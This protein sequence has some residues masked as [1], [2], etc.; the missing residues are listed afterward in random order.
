MRKLLIG[1]AL[2]AV[3]GA[4]LLA[5]GA[6]K[7]ISDLV[8]LPQGSWA[9]G[10]LFPMVDL[11]ASATKKTSVADFDARFF[12]LTDVLAVSNGGTNS[13]TALNNNRVMRSSGGAIVESNA[14]TASRALVSDTNGIP[15]HANTT[16]TELNYVSGVTSAIQT[17]IDAKQA[18]AT[19]TTKGDL[20]VATASATV[21][22]QGVGT[23]GYVLTADSAQTNGIKW[24]APA[25]KATGEVFMTAATSCPTGSVHADGT[26]ALRTG[27]TECG[28]GAC[29]NLFAAIGTTY[30]A[31]DGT[32]FYFPDTRGVFIR[33]QGSQTISAIGYTGTQG[34]TQGDQAQGH[35]HS[36]TDPGHNHVMTNML[37]YPGGGGSNYGEGTTTNTIFGSPTTDANTTG[38]AVTNPTSDGSNGTPRTGSETRPANIV[39]KYCIVY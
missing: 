10:D 6:D 1:V 7:K 33:G 18:R 35:N 9:S 36:I 29:D 28:G 27:G 4:S 17:Q 37:R 19:L 5:T 3:L 23:D 24:A 34:T 26:N 32:H 31:A 21:A 8:S 20:Y 11:S 15:V 2:L 38:I 25:A 14:I 12:K 22:R 16:T 39:M 30:G 13:S